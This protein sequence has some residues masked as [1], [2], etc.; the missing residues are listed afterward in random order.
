[1]LEAA[2]FPDL[3]PKNAKQAEKEEVE[4]KQPACKKRKRASDKTNHQKRSAHGP[5]WSSYVINNHGTKSYKQNVQF[6]TRN[7]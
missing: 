6:K 4:D 1:M 7:K 2:D 5:R 3:T